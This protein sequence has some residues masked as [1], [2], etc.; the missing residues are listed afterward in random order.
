[1]SKVVDE[2]HRIVVKFGTSLLT[3][4]SAHLNMDLMSNLAAQVAQLH[5]RGLEMIVVSSGAIASGRDKLGVTKK[6]KG[7]PSKQVM[8]SV[9]QSRLMYVYEQLFSQHDI[10]VAQALLTMAD[11]LSLSPNLAS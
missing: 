2:Y 8:A 3:G 5:H 1:M 11:R 7:I 6:I 4:E 9:G 10:T